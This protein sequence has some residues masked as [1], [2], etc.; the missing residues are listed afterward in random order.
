[1]IAG[2]AVFQIALP[3][4][5]VG[6]FLFKRGNRD[7]HAATVCLWWAAMNVLSV[8]IYAGDARIRKLMLIS[9]A[10]GQEDDGHDF[11]N[12]FSRWG[13]LSRDTI[14]AERLRAIAG[15]MF[16]LSIV[17]GVWAAWRRRGVAKGSGSD[18]V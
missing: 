14:Y 15:T 10:T 18:S 1:V 3:L 4:I 2:G 13:V 8:A 17:V 12:L 5:F 7:I 16:F 11:Y 6:Y 9:G